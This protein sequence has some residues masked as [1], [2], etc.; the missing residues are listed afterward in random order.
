MDYSSSTYRRRR[1]H[2]ILLEHSVYL[3]ISKTATTNQRRGTVNKL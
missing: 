2:M 1:G 3:P